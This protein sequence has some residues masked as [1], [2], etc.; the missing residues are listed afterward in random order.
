MNSDSKPGR[1][2][3]FQFGMRD[4]LWLLVVCCVVFAWWCDHRQQ[5]QAAAFPYVET[6]QL[7][8]ELIATYERFNRAHGPVVETNAKER[9]VQIDIGSKDGLA[10]GDVLEVFRPSDDPPGIH[11]LGEI[12]LM[13]LDKTT[14]VG[15]IMWP[16]CKIKVGDLVA[17][18]SK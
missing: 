18:R 5:S 2:R 10:K 1:L 12:R 4:L 15:T 14:A 7:R 9:F 13:V 3:W 17:T 16:A 11:L 8:A 6:E